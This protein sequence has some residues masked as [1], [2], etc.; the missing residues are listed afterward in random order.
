AEKKTAPQPQPELTLTEKVRKTQ[1]DNAKS[2]QPAASSDL[3]MPFPPPA[4][5]TPIA[6]PTAQRPA[7]NPPAKYGERS[8]SGTPETSTDA[9]ALAPPPPAP[10]APQ[11]GASIQKGPNLKEIQE[12]EAKKAAKKEE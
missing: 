11:P 12:A 8:A 9:A 5:S 3:P 1:A 6:A 10:W 7:S 2:S 4:Q